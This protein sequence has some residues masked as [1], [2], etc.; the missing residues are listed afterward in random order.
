LNRFAFALNNN[1]MHD[2]HLIVV[3]PVRLFEF[4]KFGLMWTADFM[5]G[6]KLYA[7][8][9][10][11]KSHLHV[12]IDDCIRYVVSGRFNPSESAQSLTVELMTAIRR[13]AAS[14]SGC[15]RTMVRPTTTAT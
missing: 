6:P 2:P 3:E 10:K 12:I 13:H 7:S 5:H 1:L 11:H 8:K 15:I 4:D 9:K 14:P